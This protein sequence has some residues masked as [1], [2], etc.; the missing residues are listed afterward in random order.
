MFPAPQ[1]VHE[2]L[3]KGA[4]GKSGNIPISKYLVVNN[5]FVITHAELE[6]PESQVGWIGL[7]Q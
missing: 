4:R 3:R 1:K 6:A 7:E 5:T 2:N